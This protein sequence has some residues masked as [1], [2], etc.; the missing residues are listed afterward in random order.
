[1]P[2]TL[3][4]MTEQHR[5]I[6]DWLVAHHAGEVNSCPRAL[7]L[8][9]YNTFHVTTLSDRKFRQIVSDLVLK[10]NLPICPNSAEGYYVARYQEELEHGVAELKARA[11]ALFERQRALEQARPLEPQSRLF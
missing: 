4:D 1:M 7:I 10:C 2:Y 5:Q 3:A 8:Q 9:R 11:S 6:W